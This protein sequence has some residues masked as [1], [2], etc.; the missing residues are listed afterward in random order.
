MNAPMRILSDDEMRGCVRDDDA[1]PGALNTAEGALPLR[2]LSVDARIVG[3]LAET[4]VRQRF[5]NTASVPLEATYIFPLPPRAAVTRFRFEVNDRVIEGD[6]QERGAARRTYDAAVQAGHRAAIAEEERPDVFTMRVGNLPPGEEATV[7]LTLSYPLDVVDDE[8]TFRFPLVVAP[9]YIPG[10]ALSGSDVGDGVARDTDEVPDASRISPPVLLPGYPSRVALSL[11]VEI[12]PGRSELTALASSLHAVSA[13]RGNGPTRSVRIEVTPGER[14][15]RDFILRFSSAQRA[16]SSTLAL[17]P[18]ERGVEGTF[19]LLLLPPAHD[20][21]ERRVGRDVVFVLDRSGS[22]KGWKMIAARRAVA[23]MLDTLGSHDR[24]AVIAFNNTPSRPA[25]LDVRALS[26]GTDRN[27]FRAIE[28]VTKVEAHGGTVME[29]ALDEAC[30]LL[31]GG[32]LERHRSIAFITDGQVGNEA[33][34]T[35]LLMRRAKGVHVFTLGIDEAA[36]SGFLTRIANATGGRSEIVESEARLDDALDRLHRAL[37]PPVVAELSIEG[38]GLTLDLGSVVPT[39]LPGLFP[40]AP[41]VITG[42][43]RGGAEGSVMVRGRRPDGSAFELVVDGTTTTNAAI[44]TTWAKGRLRDLEDQFEL[45]GDKS[46]AER[47]T[48]LSLERRVLCRF[49]A[50]VAV[51]RSSV[52]NTGGQNLRVTQAVE[53]ARG[54]DML[55]EGRGGAPVAKRAAPSFGQTY[56]VP[57]GA[58]PT[59]SVPTGG[60]SFERAPAPAKSAPVEDPLFGDEDSLDDEAGSASSGLPPSEFEMAPV[61]AR[62]APIAAAPAASDAPER[63]RSESDV[64]RVQAK[65]EVAA[66]NDK[67]AVVVK[68]GASVLD[69]LAGSPPSRDPLV[70]LN[71][72]IRMA[73]AHLRGHATTLFERGQLLV[74]A[75]G[76]LEGGEVLLR[77]ATLAPALVDA[78]QALA[79]TMRSVGEQARSSDDVEAGIRFALAS[80]DALSRGEVP[81]E[82]PPSTKGDRRKGTFWR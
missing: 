15:D 30:S 64:G 29:T 49:T 17:T 31:G 22:M 58:A 42:R 2:A 37:L 53:P 73:L 7:E 61:R 60:R 33:Q 40:G 68:P 55:Q 20:G 72:L 51:D 79:R 78:V 82:G 5:A 65:R 70:M 50:F 77:D 3:T 63:D 11:V 38:R 27:R 23:R 69:A 74:R 54:W 16:V 75:A 25:T 45:S 56:G 41:L 26:A 35:E 66:P 81:R 21:S 8:V 1:H 46:L 24:F 9:R 4:R 18:D 19:A 13:L 12:E 59:A 48:A 34:L 57:A 71:D 10:R 62:A 47:I 80:L 6:L 52:V 14:L 39:R 28:W 36:N 32:T 44:V 43:Y 67:A 76:V